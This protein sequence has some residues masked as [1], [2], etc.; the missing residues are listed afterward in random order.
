SLLLAA[1]ACVLAA[2]GDLHFKHHFIDTDLP[3]INYGLTDCAD[4]GHDGHPAFITGGKDKDKAIYWYEYQ[5]ADKWVR[6]VL[7]T[8]HPSDVGGKA[9]DVDGDGWIDFVTGGV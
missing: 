3:G 7:G 9:L 1:P 5:S 2:S 4:I 8:N 6:H